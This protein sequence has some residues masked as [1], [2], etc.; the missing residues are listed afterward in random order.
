MKMNKGL[1]L[2]M[3]VTLGFGV[4]IIIAQVSII[5]V[6]KIAERKSKNE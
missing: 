2:L 1:L 3:L 4:L 5:I 6:D